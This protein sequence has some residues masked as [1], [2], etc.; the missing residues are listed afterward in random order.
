MPKISAVPLRT[1]RRRGA[2]SLTST[3]SSHSLSS[4]TCRIADDDAIVAVVLSWPGLYPKEITRREQGG[5]LQNRNSCGREPS[6]C[7][8]NVNNHKILII[9]KEKKKY[10]FIFTSISFVLHWFFFFFIMGVQS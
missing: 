9:K 6:R 3:L 4:L 5:P 7:G 2:L 10:N 8:P 1:R